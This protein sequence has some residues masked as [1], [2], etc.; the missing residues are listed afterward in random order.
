[1]PV[2]L[3]VLT[4]NPCLDDGKVD[5]GGLRIAIDGRPQ[6]HDCCAQGGRVEFPRMNAV[7]HRRFQPLR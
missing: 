5:G 3:P 4:M 1:M 7:K 6:Q 2:P